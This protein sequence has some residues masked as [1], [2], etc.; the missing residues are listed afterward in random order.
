MGDF[1]TQ[2]RLQLKKQVRE[3][4]QQDRQDMGQREQLLY[5]RTLSYFDEEPSQIYDAGTDY[6]GL[7]DNA[8]GTG[9][10]LGL[11]LLLAAILVCLLALA[12]R[13]GDTLF[14]M[15]SGQ[16]LEYLRYDYISAP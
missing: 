6:S 8:G 7:G 5:G 15:T 16:I 1:S 9:G 13:R 4:Y 11:R 14:G 3:R 10:T 12:D 2:Q